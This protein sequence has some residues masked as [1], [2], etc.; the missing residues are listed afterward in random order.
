MHQK[1]KSKMVGGVFRNS[2][3]NDNNLKKKESRM[4]ISGDSFLGTSN[5]FCTFLNEKEELPRLSIL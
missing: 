1:S 4:R 2:Y 5:N 3:Y